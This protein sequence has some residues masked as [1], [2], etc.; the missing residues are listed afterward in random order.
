[1][2]CGMDEDRRARTLFATG[3]YQELLEHYEGNNP[4]THLL[5]VQSTFLQE[6]DA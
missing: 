5:R 3:A 2:A 1:M 4:D 6:R